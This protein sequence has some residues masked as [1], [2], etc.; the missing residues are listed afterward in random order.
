MSLLNAMQTRNTRTENGMVTNSSSGNKNLDLFFKMGGWNDGVDEST[1]RS[2]FSNAFYENRELALKSLFYNRDVRE[3]QGSRRTFRIMYAW[4][5][6][7]HPDDAQANL[8]N[9]PFY[10]RWDDVL[11]GLGTPIEDSVASM[12]WEEL[13]KGNAL[14]AKWM[15]RENKSQGSLAKAL[16]S[17]WGIKPKKYRRLL[18]SATKVVETLMCN[19]EWNRIDYSTVPSKAINKYRNAYTLRDGSRFGAWAKSL[20][21]P[22]SGNKINAG[23]IYPHDIIRAYTYSKST[24]KYGVKAFDDVLEAQWSSLPNYVNTDRKILPV[25][26]VSGSMMMGDALPILASV[27]LGIYISQR[28][29][30]A[31]KDAFITFSTSPTLQV[32]SGNL[33]NRIDQLLTS[34]WTQSTN[35]VAVFDLILNSAVRNGVAQSEMPDDIL[36]LSDMQF[37][38]AVGAYSETA[39]DVI[40]RKYAEAGYRVPNTV[41][42]NLRTSVGVPVSYNK[43][44]TALV[45]GFSPSIMKNVL[46]GEVNPVSVMTRTLL[47]ERYA[48]VVIL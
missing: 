5:C 24:Y 41:F 26:D 37:N 6:R 22:N 3:G 4:L 16:I 45:S 21:S 31:F 12:I 18:S 20:S 47:S 27:A 10:G 46:S 30:G 42:W 33:A 14:C 44:G 15:P 32:L 48:R 17:I 11:V 40:E 39:M 23:A 35:I 19:N 13:N 25:C 34:G 9:V 7:N 2:V 29:V 8:Y 38:E 1:I 28:N 36:I 43:D